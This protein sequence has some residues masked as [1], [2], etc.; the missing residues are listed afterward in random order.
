MIRMMAKQYSHMITHKSRSRNITNT[1]RIN[2]L[3]KYTTSWRTPCWANFSKM[4][5]KT[6]KINDNL[7][8]STSQ[9]NRTCLEVN[10]SNRPY[11]ARSHKHRPN[12]FKTPGCYSIR[13]PNIFPNSL[14]IPKKICRNLWSRH[15]TSGLLS[16]KSNRRPWILIEEF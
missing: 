11:N 3:S 5:L 14:R 8:I 16:R 12:S 10:H 13:R 15:R 2:L 6:T 4:N 7:T 9:Y 1:P